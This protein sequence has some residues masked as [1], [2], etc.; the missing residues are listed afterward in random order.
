MLTQTLP[1]HH[2]A[3]LDLDQ[4]KENSIKCCDKIPCP[5]C[6]SPAIRLHFSQSSLQE[7]SCETC[8]YLLVSCEKTGN[9]IEAYAP[10]T[11]VTRL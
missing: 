7:T 8:D 5:N 2:R 3:I 4:G 10:G 9:V 6:G 1:I 11:I